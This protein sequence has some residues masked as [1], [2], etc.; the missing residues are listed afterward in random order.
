MTLN[1]NCTGLY[2]TELCGYAQ[3]CC[4]VILVHWHIEMTRYVASVALVLSLLCSSGCSNRNAQPARAMTNRQVMIEKFIRDCDKANPPWTAKQKANL[5][6]KA[7]AKAVLVTKALR[8]DIR[9]KG[10]KLKV[11]DWPE[12]INAGCIDALSV[13]VEGSVVSPEQKRVLHEICRKYSDDEI[14]ISPD[15]IATGEH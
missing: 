7:K 4:C 13:S 8:S 10:A 5:R 11:I 9:M 14:D 6:Q 1:Q 12:A 3:H 2:N 15:P